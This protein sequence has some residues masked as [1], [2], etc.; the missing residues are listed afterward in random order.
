MRSIII[1]EFVSTW[2]KFA[3]KFAVIIGDI[4][5]VAIPR[6]CTSEHVSEAVLPITT[7]SK[8]CLSLIICVCDFGISVL[9]LGAIGLSSGR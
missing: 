8:H 4:F 5:A 1:R 7:T 2:D 9:K 6:V 3:R